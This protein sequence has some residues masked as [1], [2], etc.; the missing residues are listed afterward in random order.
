MRE[1]V[2]VHKASKA[3][4]QNR[5]G[6][7]PG[8]TRRKATTSVPGRSSV[9]PGGGFSG[10]HQGTRKRCPSHCHG[11]PGVG[12]VFGA[13]NEDAIHE[14]KAGQGQQQQQQQQP[15]RTNTTPIMP[16]TLISSGRGFL[17]VR[18]RSV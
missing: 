9:A 3:L 12:G 5:R 2:A 17:V 4:S 15:R 16:Q 8:I 7:R 14:T 10:W 6:D 13:V 11:Q 18:R 1:L